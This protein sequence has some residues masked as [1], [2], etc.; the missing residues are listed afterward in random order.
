MLGRWIERGPSLVASVIGER[1]RLL[2]N[3]MQAPATELSHLRTTLSD[4]QRRH[5]SLKLEHTQLTTSNTS[6]Q[7][8]L[9]ALRARLD[10]ETCRA[11]KAE[12]TVR[13]LQSRLDDE[14]ARVNIAERSTR[15]LRTQLKDETERTRNA[16]RRAD[17]QM[18][19]A[20]T[21]VA[22]LLRAEKQVY[23]CV[24]LLPG[25][26][27]HDFEALKVS[28]HEMRLEGGTILNA[29]GNETIARKRG[30]GRIVERR[31]WD[32]EVM[33]DVTEIVGV[34]YGQVSTMEVR[35]G[36]SKRGPPVTS[37]GVGRNVGDSNIDR[38][39]NDGGT[40][41][42]GDGGNTKRAWSK[43][44][45]RKRNRF[46]NGM[47]QAPAAEKEDGAK[48]T[49]VVKDEVAERAGLKGEAQK[50]FTGRGAKVE[51][52]VW[53][54]SAQ[55]SICKKSS[56]CKKRRNRKKTCKGLGEPSG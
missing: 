12:Q 46:R 50:D 35:N 7:K 9:S 48:M 30:Q 45:K 40:A 36:N 22:M 15:G 39:R 14:S 17:A 5:N 20:N 49:S 19:R 54:G 56:T 23:E 53:D 34:K 31:Q 21:L 44:D 4:E 10:E 2:Q 29:T 26:M 51:S 43:A 32:Q 3:A 52:V 27:K 47:T 25:H 11:D 16:T 41:N 33:K 42:M 37:G 28:M 13:Q 1:N 8:E 18:S 24:H 55:S 38:A 6:H